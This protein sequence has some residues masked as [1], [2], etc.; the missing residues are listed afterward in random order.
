MEN[1]PQSFLHILQTHSK[2]LIAMSGLR[3][4]LHYPFIIMSEIEVTRWVYH[5]AKP[6]YEISKCE[7][8][9][10]AR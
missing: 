1:I 9:I 7:L 4:F 2:P 5:R 3:C 8:P 10:T 6:F